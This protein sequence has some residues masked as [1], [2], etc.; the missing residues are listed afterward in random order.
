MVYLDF[1]HLYKVLVI[2][3]YLVLNV[4]I[5]THFSFKTIESELN[6]ALQLFLHSPNFAHIQSNKSPRYVKR[7]M[8]M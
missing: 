4:N 6:I 2:H 7:D 5:A 1:L 8:N 3:N